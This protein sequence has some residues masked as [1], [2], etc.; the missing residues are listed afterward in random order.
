MD[1]I[2]SKI[3]MRKIPQRLCQKICEKISGKKSGKTR[4]S[5]LSDWLPSEVCGSPFLLHIKFSVTQL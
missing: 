5:L 2:I 1:F 3:S 4:D